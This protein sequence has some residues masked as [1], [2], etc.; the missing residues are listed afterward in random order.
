MSVLRSLETLNIDAGTRDADDEDDCFLPMSLRQLRNAPPPLRSLEIY[1]RQAP[2]DWSNITIFAP[3]L[4]SL[5]LTFHDVDPAGVPPVASFPRLRTIAIACTADEPSILPS[6]GTPSLISLTY[7]EVGYAD[8]NLSHPSF[9]TFLSANPQLQQVFF[10][11]DNHHFRHPPPTRLH[12]ATKLLRSNGLPLDALDHHELSPFHPKADLSH[13]EMELELLGDAFRRALTFGSNEVE[14]MMDLLTVIVTP[15]A[16][17]HLC[18]PSPLS[19]PPEV[20]SHILSSL[21]HTLPDNP[22]GWRVRNATLATAALVSKEWCAAAYRELYGDLRLEWVGPRREAI[23]DAFVDNN[24][25]NSLVRK[26]VAELVTFVEWE[27]RWW[28]RNGRGTIG[29]TEKME[30]KKQWKVF[31]TTKLL[32]SRGNG[33]AGVVGAW[34]T[35]ADGGGGGG[36]FLGLDG[37]GVGISPQIFD[38]WKLGLTGIAERDFSRR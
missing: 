6:F 11:T 28:G 30:G 18:P 15:Q 2:L 33:R 31:S 1:D 20:L 25:L 7:S 34:G 17:D 4:E 12:L 3:A 29:E 21:A 24:D 19:I 37:P 9:H 10:G 36:L 13:D 38:G 32:S 14:R 22:E 23:L 5:H 27:N 26:V 8:P 35:W 16:P